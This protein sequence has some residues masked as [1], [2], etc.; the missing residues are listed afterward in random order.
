[1]LYLL[2]FILK[3]LLV[4]FYRVYLI[5]REFWNR[6]RSVSFVSTSASSVLIHL[7]LRLNLFLI[8]VKGSLNLA[9]MVE[10]LLFPFL[11][12]FDMVTRHCQS[13]DTPLIILIY[14]RKMFVPLR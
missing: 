3:L 5:H 6:I 2:M 7:G 12:G 4:C 14:L 1:M 10:L 8:N 9:W 11:V 13:S